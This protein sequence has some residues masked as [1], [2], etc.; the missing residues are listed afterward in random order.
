MTSTSLF[1]KL[2][3]YEIELGRIEKYEIQDK[4]SKV[5]TLKVDSKEE[6][7]EDVTDENENF[8]LLVKSLGKFFLEIMINL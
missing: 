3:E 8:L 6:Q 7:E 1:G 4:K 5:V 2:Q